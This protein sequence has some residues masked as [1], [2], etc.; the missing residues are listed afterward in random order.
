MQSSSTEYNKKSQIGHASH[1]K[2]RTTSPCPTHTSFYYWNSILN[3]ESFESAFF[4]LWQQ[5]GN[6]VTFLDIQRRK[7]TE[8]DINSFI[9][10]ID[11]NSIYV[12]DI[13]AQKYTT[14]IVPTFYY[15]EFMNMN[16]NWNQNKLS[17]LFIAPFLV[18][19]FLVA[20]VEYDKIYTHSRKIYLKW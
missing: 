6:L 7:W 19:H 3:S 20:L 12:L 2:P 1:S 4:L 15:H 10:K 18:L 11:M 8:L 14:T 5:V 13:Y 9:H 16:L 17:L